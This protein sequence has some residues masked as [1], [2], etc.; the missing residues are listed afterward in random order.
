MYIP[1][2]SIKCK[3]SRHCL[4]G[5]IR[6]SAG[7]DRYGRRVQPHEVRRMGLSANLAYGGLVATTRLIRFSVRRHIWQVSENSTVSGDVGDSQAAVGRGCISDQMHRSLENYSVPWDL[8]V[9]SLPVFLPLSFPFLTPNSS[10][11]RLLT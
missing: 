1:Y 5:G 7:M 3:D 2:I 10:I 9:Y 8:W 4:R 6:R 11:I